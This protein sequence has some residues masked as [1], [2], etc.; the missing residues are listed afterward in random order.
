MRERGRARVAIEQADVEALFERGDAA[1]H[2]GLGGVQLFGGETE[3]LQA[4]EPDEGL[5]KPDIHGFVWG[6]RK[7]PS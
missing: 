3:I 4:G 5:E 7:S 2:R 6:S 1:R